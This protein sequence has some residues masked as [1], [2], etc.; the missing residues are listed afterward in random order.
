MMGSTNR[1]ASPIE[2]RERVRYHE[3]WHTSEPSTTIL[4]DLF[5]HYGPVDLSSRLH[6]AAQWIAWKKGRGWSTA[7]RGIEASNL[8]LE[9][10]RHL[11]DVV[12]SLPDEKSKWSPGRYGG[13]MQGIS[14][15]EANAEFLNLLGDLHT[16]LWTASAVEKDAAVLAAVQH[17]PS[18]L[19][20]SRLS[21]YLALSDPLNYPVINQKSHDRL[22]DLICVT[23]PDS[24]AVT[25]LDCLDATRKYRQ[26]LE[27]YAGLDELNFL[28][29]DQLVTDWEIRLPD[30]NW[31]AQQ[32]GETDDLMTL[33]K[34]PLQDPRQRT[35]TSETAVEYVRQLLEEKY[36]GSQI[37]KM[38]PNNRGYDIR[39]LTE[40]GEQFYVEVKGTRLDKPRFFL[41]ETERRFG[42]QKGDNYFLYIVTSVAEEPKHCEIKDPFG[43]N[44]HL[45]ELTPL[46]YQGSAI[47]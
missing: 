43:A 6:V 29:L 25:Y 20:V 35:E 8:P 18:G 15:L 27:Q 23:I 28:V 13:F 22:Q 46:S 9:L 19:G 42:E 14:M 21:E 1:F 11:L 2:V 31:L 34:P 16:S 47:C 41:T 5:A 44:V 26:Q 30:T 40:H 24:P 33:T 45:V 39:V 37:Q 7:R 32:L 17:N 4:H 3:L 10:R 12:D 38:R 36:P